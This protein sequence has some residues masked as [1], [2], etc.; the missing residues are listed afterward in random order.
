MKKRSLDRKII[1]LY[2]SSVLLKEIN[3]NVES[4]TLGF[5]ILMLSNNDNNILNKKVLISR[6]RL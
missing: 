5:Y 6:G 1:P 3:L 2:S 4:V